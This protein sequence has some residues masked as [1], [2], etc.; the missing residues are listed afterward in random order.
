M[1]AAPEPGAFA[2]ASALLAG[3]LAFTLA[4]C[5]SRRHGLD[6]DEQHP[7]QGGRVPCR[8][9]AL[10]QATR[11]DADRVRPRTDFEHLDPGEAY[12]DQDYTVTSATQRPLYSYPP[13]NASKLEPDVAA[14]APVDL[15]RRQ[16]RDGAHQA[17]HLL[18]PAGQ[19]RSELRRRRLRD[20]ARRQPERR[21]PLLRTLLRGHR[22]RGKCQGRPDSRNRNAEQPYDRLP[23]DQAH[24]RAA[25]GC[26]QPA[27]LR[28]RCRRNSPSRSTLTNPRRT[29]PNT[30][31][32]PGRTC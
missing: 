9:A 31:W 28:A 22:R 6:R 1:Q 29:A 13:N 14:G 12:S 11:R 23:P 19:P 25:R 24:G 16:D 3:V 4:A 10:R 27:A 18:Q 5:G 8:P 30:S 17:A 7:A 2:L 32:R 21:Q 15:R 20:R 26:A